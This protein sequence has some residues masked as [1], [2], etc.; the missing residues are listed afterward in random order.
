MNWILVWDVPTRFFHWLLV[1]LVGNLFYTGFAGE[2]VWHFRLAYVV[3]TLI[4]FRICWGFIGST[5]SRFSSF[6]FPSLELIDYIKN[7]FNP[8]PLKHYTGH[9]P[10][11]GLSVM[12][13]L[14]LILIQVISG[15]FTTDDIASEGALYGLVSTK[16]GSFFTKIHKLNFKLL[17]SF[18]ILHI[19]AVLFYLFYRKENLIKPMLSGY[20]TTQ[21]NLIIKSTKI[22]VALILLLISTFLVVIIVNLP[23]LLKLFK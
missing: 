1:F 19:S 9:N 13:L 7:L 16:V 3:L 2:M 12:V 10:L 5:Y 21:E 18:I 22:W 15:L 11:G 17:L 23:T 8:H 14:S 6:L 20:K 4:F